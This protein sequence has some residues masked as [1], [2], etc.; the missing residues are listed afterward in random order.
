MTKSQLFSGRYFANIHLKNLG[1][2]PSIK[3]SFLDQYYEA[4]HHKSF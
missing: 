1:W 3:V 2:D 4:I